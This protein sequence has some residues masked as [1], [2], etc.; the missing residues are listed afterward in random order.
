M[1]KREKKH[2]AS[3]I[4]DQVS[5]FNGFSVSE[6][7]MEEDIA[8]AAENISKYLSRKYISKKKADE[9]LEDAIING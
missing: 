3:L 4:R 8:K 2:V 1:N 6:V 9:I 7:Q 5:Y